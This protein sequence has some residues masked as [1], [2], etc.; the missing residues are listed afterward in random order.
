MATAT[1]APHTVTTPFWRRRSFRR[2]LTGWLFAAPILIYFTI[3]VFGPILASL[4]M[5][6]Y[7]W[8]GF[9]PLSQ[10]KFV[11]L[12]HVTEAFGDEKFLGS[13]RNTATYAIVVVLCG[14]G[15]GL[16]LALALNGVTKF[17]GFV[18]STYYL[19]VMLP[20]TAMSLLWGLMYQPRYGFINQVLGMVGIPPVKWLINPNIAL[21]SICLMVIW[22]G[23]GWYMVIFLAGLKAIP[24]EFYEAAQ[25]DGATAWQ[26]FWKITLPLLKPTLLFVIVVTVIGSLQVFSPIFIMTQGGPANATNVVVYWV[27]LTAFQFMRFG[28]ATT[29]AV[30]LF[31]VILVITLIQLRLFREGG[32]QS[33]Y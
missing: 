10:A 4:L 5:M 27:Y 26:R 22:K 6:F 19:P 21:Y 11:G 7:D 28:Y 24:E 31:V 33:Y 14:V 25:M 16:L 3:F 18:R 15:V 30:I 23:L 17:V 2:G 32:L 8:N 1:L 9:G 13:F 20:M 12:S 29:L